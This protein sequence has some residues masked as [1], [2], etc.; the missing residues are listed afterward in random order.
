MSKDKQLNVK[1]MTDDEI[2]NEYKKVKK[3]IKRYQNKHKYAVQAMTS[4]KEKLE[5]AEGSLATDFQKR[6]DRVKRDFHE[7]EDTLKEVQDRFDVLDK[8][9]KK[10]IE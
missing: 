9:Y 2:V 7:L 4:Y 5:D 10:V 6:Y 8:A 3:E 1:K